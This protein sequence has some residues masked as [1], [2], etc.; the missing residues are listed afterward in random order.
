MPRQIATITKNVTKYFSDTTPYKI[1]VTT[2]MV[3]GAGTDANVSVTLIGTKD[4]S[5]K[6]LLPK[7]TKNAFERGC[8]D[9]FIV[10]VTEIGNNNA[11]VH[12]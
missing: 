3:R 6:T 11:D 5:K 8:C 1:K 4:Q 12:K 7:K 9:E 10:Y 2:G